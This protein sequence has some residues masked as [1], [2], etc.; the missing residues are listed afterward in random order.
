MSRVASEKSPR[1]IGERKKLQRHRWQSRRDTDAEIPAANRR[2]DAKKAKRNTENKKTG[3]IRPK[4]PLKLIGT[5]AKK[6]SLKLNLG[7]G[8]NSVMGIG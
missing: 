8:K 7:V 3:T 1:L 2:G 5:R 6:E 4:Q